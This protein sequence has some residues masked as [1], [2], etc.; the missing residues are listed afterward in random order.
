MNIEI[1]QSGKIEQL[2]C[3]TIIAFSNRKQYAVALPKLVKRNIFLVHK[4]QTRQLRYKLFCIGIYWCI[5]D[6]LREFSLIIIDC[7]YKG[8]ETLIKSLLLNLIRIE[9]KEFDDKLIRFGQIGKK[10]NAHNVAIDVFRRHRKPNRIITLG[11]IE[12]LLRK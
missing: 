2:N 11:D 1:D 4:S 3:D 12:S 5:K 6:Y 9:Y 8:N 7:E 10:S